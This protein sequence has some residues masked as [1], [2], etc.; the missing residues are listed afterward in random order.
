MVC[1]ECRC[2]KCTNVYSLRF[3]VWESTVIP[4]LRFPRSQRSTPSSRRPQGDSFGSDPPGR[5]S[6]L[7][8]VLRIHLVSSRPQSSVT[9]PR[10]LRSTPL[11]AQPH[12]SSDTNMDPPPRP[13]EGTDEGHCPEGGVV[14]SLSPVT[15][16]G[17]GCRDQSRRAVGTSVVFPDR[18]RG[19]DTRDPCV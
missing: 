15:C 10:P 17:E 2:S 3:L 18:H 13:G 6:W 8:P 12:V 11:V 14:A 4:L 1:V 16:A 9:D 7:P 5:P 19:T